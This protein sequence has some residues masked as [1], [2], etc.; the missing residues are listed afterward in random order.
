MQE[1]RVKG[2]L[3]YKKTSQV[4]KPVRSLLI[5]EGEEALD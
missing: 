4:F 3:M 1:L 2:Q 5:P